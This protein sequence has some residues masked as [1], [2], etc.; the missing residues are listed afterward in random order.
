MGCVWAVGVVSGRYVDDVGGIMVLG[1]GADAVLVEV[2]DVVVGDGDGVHGVTVVSV[3]QITVACSAMGVLIDV[4]DVVTA[5]VMLVVIVVV[6]VGVGRALPSF[7]DRVVFVV[8]VVGLVADANVVI[9]GDDV[10][11]VV[12][13]G[14][15]V[16]V[17]GG[18]VVGG[19]GVVMLVVVVVVVCC[20]S[21]AK[22]V[23]VGGVGNLWCWRITNTSH[24]PPCVCMCA[25]NPFKRCRR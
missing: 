13:V 4:A 22:V 5:V 11:G 15:D 12:G 17:V 2:V 25:S 6:N 10:S 16:V 23:G 19:V 20:M 18:G 21:V 7:D 9:A 8:G 24:P 14:V 1:L 3:M